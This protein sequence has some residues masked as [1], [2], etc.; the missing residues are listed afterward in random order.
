VIRVGQ[1]MQNAVRMQAAAASSL[2]SHPK[3]GTISGYDPKKQAVKVKLQPEGNETGWIPLG[4]LWVGNGWGLVCAPALESQ[5]EVSFVDGNLDAGS[6]TLRFFSNVEAGP[7]APGGE[8]WLVHKNGQ[9]I[10]LTNDGALTLDDGHG[11][12][13]ALDGAGNIASTGTWTHTGTFTATVDVIGGGKHL[14][15]HT[16]SGVQTGG[17]NSGP[18]V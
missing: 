9:S 6:A 2:R 8:F 11:A 17:G 12:T 7:A 4:T 14:K 10:K 15:T 16:H 18:P 3:I 5:V 13:I 1:L